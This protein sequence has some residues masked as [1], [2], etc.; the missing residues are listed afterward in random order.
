M[1]LGPS[2][3]AVAGST[4]AVRLNISVKVIYVIAMVAKIIAIHLCMSLLSNLHHRQNLSEYQ[5]IGVVTMA[6][7][8]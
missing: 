5:W 8:N 7:W 3:S 1:T 2:V 4:S 6:S